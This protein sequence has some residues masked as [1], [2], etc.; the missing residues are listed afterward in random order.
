VRDVSGL[1]INNEAKKIVR[2]AS[3]FSFTRVSQ[4]WPQR[5]TLS[6]ATCPDLHPVS[7]Q[8]ARDSFLCTSRQFLLYSHMLLREASIALLFVLGLVGLFASTA[9]DLLFHFQ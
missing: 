8:V 9:N 4:R 7:A 5:S 2:A 3:K 1:Q 6:P